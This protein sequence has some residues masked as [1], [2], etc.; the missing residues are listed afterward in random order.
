MPNCNEGKTSYQ[1]YQLNLQIYNNCKLWFISEN[2]RIF[3][4]NLKHALL[5]KLI[6]P[7]KSKGVLIVTQCKAFSGVECRDL[8][9]LY[10]PTVYLLLS[11]SN[12]S[13]SLLSNSLAPFL[14]ADTKVDNYNI[15]VYKQRVDIHININIYAYGH[16][17]CI[18]VCISIYTI[19]DIIHPYRAFISKNASASRY[20]SL[21]HYYIATLKPI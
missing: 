1:N 14:R 11:L 9:Y 4:V 13:S 21:L 17:Q 7:C 10:I 20:F 6:E 16:R 8:I 12:P 15:Q 19:V 18:S 5:A 2:L 3:I